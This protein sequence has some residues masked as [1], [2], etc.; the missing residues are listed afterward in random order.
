MLVGVPREVK[1][2]E[3]RVAITPAGVRE[4]T[5]RGHQ[6]LLERDAGAGAGLP[7]DEFVAAGARISADPDEVWAAA[8]LVLK[9]KEPVPEEYHRLRADQVLF[10][11]LH[12][13]A[14]KECTD[15]LVTAGATAVAYETVRLPDGSLPLLAPMSE[16]AGRMAPQV[17]AHHLQR[18]AGGRGVL[19]GGVSGVPA[20]KIAVIGAGVSGMNAATIA[21]GF[22]AEV[23]VL[24]T[25]INRLR[26][27]DFT[28]R[29]HLQTIM[30]NAYEVERACLWAD[31][32]IG[33]VL[34]P[35]AKAPTLVSNELV[36][37]MRPGS[38]LVDISIDQGGCFADSRPTTHDEP[39]FGVHESIFYCVANMPGAVPNT[40][41]RA[42]TN[43]TLPYAITLADQG[44]AAAADD[45]ALGA[46]V[47][48]A[49][50]RVVQP[51]VAAAHGL[52]VVALRD[53]FDDLPD[54]R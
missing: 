4:L 20:G 53:V 24:D 27:I 26:Q 13:A 25:N 23:M 45:P 3:Y 33:A 52:P 14:S 2:H 36:S 38:V 49:A 40:S 18:T 17:G 22:Q 41:T 12:L 9:V 48:V 54:P 32:V 39:V 6:V 8:G 1:N 10:T 28:Y 15:A 44:I 35:G 46:G 30:S 7:D 51:E 37:R 5:G 29:G 42:L 50:G 31:L 21:L 16:V 47:N 43:V 11:Y 34:V 19:L